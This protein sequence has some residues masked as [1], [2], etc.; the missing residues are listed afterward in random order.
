MNAEFVKLCG[1]VGGGLN[2]RLLGLTI[3]IGSGLLSGTEGEVKTE[4]V[5]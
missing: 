4:G 5:V 2:D 3:L 1:G